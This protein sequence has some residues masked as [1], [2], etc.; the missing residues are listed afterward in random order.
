M[1]TTRDVGKGPS[2]VRDP[3]LPGEPGGG[4][5]RFEVR[6]RTCGGAPDCR[7]STDRHSHLPLSP[8]VVGASGPGD[9]LPLICELLGTYTD[10]PGV[11]W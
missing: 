5:G 11:L 9:S 8:A 4:D 10:R 3:P 6:V 1:G 2:R 7:L